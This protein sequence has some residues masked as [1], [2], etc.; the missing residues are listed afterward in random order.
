MQEYR[1][2]ISG[3]RDELL[4]VNANLKV[5]Q[6]IR[7]FPW[8]DLSIEPDIV[9]TW[10]LISENLLTVTAIGLYKLAKDSKDKRSHEEKIKNLGVLATWVAD[11][12]LTHRKIE[13]LKEFGDRWNRKAWVEQLARLKKIRTSRAHLR[14]LDSY[15][16]QAEGVSVH[17]DELVSLA[18]ALESGYLF[19]GLGFKRSVS[20]PYPLSNLQDVFNAIGM[21]SYIVNE[22]ENSASNPDEAEMWAKTVAGFSTKRRASI[23]RFREMKSLPPLRP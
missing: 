10:S 13:F 22:Q 19:L 23:N 5:L 2:H 17:L 7:D 1:A 3:L 8:R 12:F 16:E 11:Q 21:D 9:A 20:P 6:L 14:G 4:L 18:A 15:M